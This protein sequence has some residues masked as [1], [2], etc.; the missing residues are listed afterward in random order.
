MPEY[1]ITHQNGRIETKEARD[2]VDLVFS[3]RGN[4]KSIIKIEENETTPRIPESPG[5]GNFPIK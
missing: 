1:T 5:W 2:I 4:Y 3:Y